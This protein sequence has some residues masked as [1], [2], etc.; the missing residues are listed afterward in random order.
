[1]ELPY[2]PFRRSPYLIKQQTNQRRKIMKRI[3]FILAVIV[4]FAG[5]LY[6]GPQPCEKILK[7]EQCVQNK[8]ATTGKACNWEQSPIAATAGKCTCVQPQPLP[9]EKIAKKEECVQTK[10]ATTG[11]AC[12]WTAT[13]AVPGGKCTCIQPQPKPCK[14][15]TTEKEC[16]STAC[17]ETSKPCNWVVE[18]TGNKHC[19]CLPK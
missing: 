5:N 3:L 12:T 6:A 9:C 17:K 10:C 7:K 15:I 19:A 14:E 16:V 2:I 1:M 4:V 8:C 13:A 11:K 18:P